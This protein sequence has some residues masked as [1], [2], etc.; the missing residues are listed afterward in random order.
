MTPGVRRDDVPVEPFQRAFLESGLSAYELARRM[1]LWRSYT[2]SVR[3]DSTR[4]LRLL[5]LRPH[6][7]KGGTRTNQRVRISTALHLAEVLNLDPVDV[8]L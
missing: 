7:G 1:G 5:G 6:P 8:G 4:A 3:P 2:N